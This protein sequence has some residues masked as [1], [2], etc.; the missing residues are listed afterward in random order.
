MLKAAG[1][2]IRGRQ[3]CDWEK[4]CIY[5]CVFTNTLTFVCINVIQLWV[6]QPIMTYV[7]FVIYVD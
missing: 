5:I 7:L 6:T 3:A 2:F 4:Q 1:G